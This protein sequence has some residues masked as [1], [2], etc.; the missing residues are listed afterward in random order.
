VLSKTLSSEKADKTTFVDNNAIAEIKKIKEQSGNDILLIGSP[1]VT[2]LLIENNLID[3]YW[4]F[5]NPI[6]LGEGIPAFSKTKDSIKLELMQNIKF[7]NG[8]TAMHYATKK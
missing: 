8:V 2:R 6:I 7:S 1:S 5:V 4:L 3:D